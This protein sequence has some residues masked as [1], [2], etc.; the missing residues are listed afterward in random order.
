MS[1]VN[2]DLCRRTAFRYSVGMTFI[3]TMVPYFGVTTW[4]FAID[5]L[6]LNAWLAYLGYQFYRHGDS[7]SSRRLFRFS[8]IHL[9]A[10]IVLMLISKKQYGE[11]KR[12]VDAEAGVIALET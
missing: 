3:C 8:L 5:S 6:P 1:V 11:V 4:T 10:L 12:I 2:P 9:P 7:K